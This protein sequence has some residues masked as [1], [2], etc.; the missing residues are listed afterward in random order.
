MGLNSKSYVGIVFLLFI[1]ISCSRGND[2]AL[3]GYWVSTTQTTFITMALKAENSMKSTMPRANPKP[4]KTITHDLYSI[5]Q[6]LDLNAQR[7]DLSH[8][9]TPIDATTRNSDS[10][11]IS[12][13]KKLRSMNGTALVSG[14]GGRNVSL[15]SDRVRNQSSHKKNFWR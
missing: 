6:P 14:I 1:Q 7:D 8:K 9:L 12:N 2:G 15:G 10:I 11:D 5:I 13:M 4:S 3:M